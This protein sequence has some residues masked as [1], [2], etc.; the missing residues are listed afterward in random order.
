MAQALQLKFCDFCLVP[1]EK[2][3]KLGGEC[4]QVNPRGPNIQSEILLRILTIPRQ[5]SHIG[6]I[7][8]VN[9]PRDDEL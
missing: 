1:Q 2:E 3:P 9:T 8:V 7:L 4:R 6:R 5:D